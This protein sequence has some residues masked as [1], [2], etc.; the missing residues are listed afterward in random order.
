MAVAVQTVLVVHFVAVAVQTVHSVV[1]ADSVA[2]AVYS[3]VAG[4]V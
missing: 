1:V 3:A 2:V 4:F